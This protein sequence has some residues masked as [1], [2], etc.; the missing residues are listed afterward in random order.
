MEAPHLSLSSNLPFVKGR[1]YDTS[2]RI[3]EFATLQ[4]NQVTRT[5]SK[6]S[7]A[8]NAVPLV[9]GPRDEPLDGQTSSY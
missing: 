7:D 3:S 9:A 6:H 4:G 5:F 2:S 1:D 8:A